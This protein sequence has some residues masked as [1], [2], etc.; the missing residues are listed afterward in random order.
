MRDDHVYAF[1]S[2]VDRWQPRL[3]SD[4]LCWGSVGAHYFNDLLPLQFTHEAPAHVT[5]RVNQVQDALGRSILI[6]NLSSNLVFSHNEMGEADFLNS[7]AKARGCGLLLD[8][9]NVYVNAMQPKI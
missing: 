4:H 3:V 2:L 1:A 8:V 7:L 9:T 5:G 6:E